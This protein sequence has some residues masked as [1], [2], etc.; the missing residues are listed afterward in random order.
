MNTDRDLLLKGIRFLGYTI[1]LMF[2]APLTLYEAFKNQENLLYW[3]VLI[4][5]FLL[6][7]GAIVMGFR[8]IKTIVDA[9]FGKKIKKP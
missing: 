4:V 1:A 5:G 8:S 7:I 9:F 3:P 2:L 6:A